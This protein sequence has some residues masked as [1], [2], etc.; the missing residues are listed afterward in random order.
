MLTKLIVVD[1]IHFIRYKSKMMHC[2]GSQTLSNKSSHP[3]VVLG[4]GVLKQC[5]KFIGESCKVSLF[6]MGVLL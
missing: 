6:S 2:L 5:S 1:S 3:E 4:K